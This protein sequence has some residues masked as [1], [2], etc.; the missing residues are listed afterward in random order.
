MD[1]H[2]NVSIHI[3]SIPAWKHNTMM[4]EGHTGLCGEAEPDDFAL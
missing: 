2:I 1:E 4:N 3:Y